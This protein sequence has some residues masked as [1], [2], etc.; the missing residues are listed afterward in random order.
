MRYRSSCNSLKILACIKKKRK[1]LI[2]LDLKSRAI[3]K[4]TIHVCNAALVPENNN[5]SDDVK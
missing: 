5:V 2:P 3:N 4:T 1:H